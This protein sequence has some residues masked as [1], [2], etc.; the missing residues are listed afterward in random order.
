[1]TGSIRVCL[2]LAVIGMCFVTSCGQAL[3]GEKLIEQ[4]NAS[5]VKARNLGDEAE[6]KRTKAKEKSESGDREA[7][8]RL[9]EDAAKLFGQASD[10]LKEAAE[11]ATELAKLKSPLWYE[12]YFSLQSKLIRNLAELGAGAHDELVIRKTGPPTEHQVQLWKENINRI[13]KEND[14]FRQQIAAIESRQGIV[15]IKE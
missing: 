9:I 8:D 4:I 10:A 13:A 14:E 12:G 2:S 15:L 1:M 5:K 3:E 7:H 11:N 6:R